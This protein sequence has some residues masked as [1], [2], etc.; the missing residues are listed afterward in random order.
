MNTRKLVGLGVA[1]ALPVT[2]VAAQPAT[3]Y[4]AAENGAA[5]IGD[6][7]FPLDG[8]G[9]IDVQSYRIADKWDFD[10]AVLSGRTT[11]RL[12]TT[13]DLNAF[14]L[15]FLLKVDG[16][17]VDGRK[18]RFKRSKGH[19]LTVKLPEAAAAGSPL[20]VVV[21]YADQPGRYKYAGERNWLS[22]DTEVVTMNEPHMAP[23]W[24][25][26]ND[27][28]LDKATYRFD[29]TVA[30]GLQAV[31]N[32]L[33]K[34]KRT[35]G[36]WTTYR[37][38]AKDPM[39]SYLAFFAAG[40]YDVEKGETAG[41]PWVN[42]VSKDLRPKQVKTAQ[43]WLAKSP[44]I[45]QWLSTE[46]G[47]YPF[48]ASG[49]LV[50][51]LGV[52]FALENQTRPTY[53]YVGGGNDSLLV[54]EL[55]HQWF[56]DDVAVHHWDDIWLNEGFASYMEARYAEVTGGPTTAQWLRDSYDGLGAGD[57]I[58][59]VAPGAPGSRKIFHGSVYQRGSMALAALR[60]VVGDQAFNTTL[61]T[62][63]EQ[64]AGGNGEIAEFTALAEQVSGQ[65]LD[66]F[67][68]AWL[69]AKARPADTAANGLG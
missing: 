37:W 7:Y 3:A 69:Y 43:R 14:N 11:I 49:G 1:L 9:G 39:T 23:W 32:G 50:T 12:V 63:L 60:K 47:A 16:V 19:E 31:A 21:K 56:G 41:L 22:N 35:R 66:A 64:K 2:L 68:D 29:I 27:H 34:G 55:A 48:E 45:V 38:V 10:S 51:G 30:K 46:L 61:R 20:K 6:P 65:D 15:D 58:W 52:G 67:F 53:P 25:P 36:S 28:P 4:V 54:H 59:K 26:A 8:N 44:G 57:E 17:T 40:R 24:F 33:P 13:Q 42:V 5:G 18:A 62:W